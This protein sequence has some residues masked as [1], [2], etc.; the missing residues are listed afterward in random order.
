MVRAAALFHDAIYDPRSPTNEADSAPLAAGALA[1]ARLGRR[2]AWHAVAAL[3][4]ATAGHDT[5]VA[6][7]DAEAAVLF[8]ADL[9]ILGSSPAEY[10]AYVTGVRAEYAHVDD[11]GWRT[12]RASGAADVPRTASRSTPRRRCAPPASAGHGPTSLRSWP[13][14]D[15]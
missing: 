7:G 3:I 4:E 10:Q 11:A 9:A 14:C 13:R 15:Q 6:R 2:S 8:D 5:A 12:G 1:P